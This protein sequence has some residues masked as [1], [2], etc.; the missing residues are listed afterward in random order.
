MAP[1]GR[2]GWKAAMNKLGVRMGLLVGVMLTVP[3]LAVFYVGY[4]LAGLPFTPFVPLDWASRMLPG[5]IITFGIDTM[6]SLIRALGLGVADTAKLA[7]QFISVGLTV[8]IGGLTGALTFRVLRDRPTE[9]IRQGVAAG[10]LLGIVLF[11]LQLSLPESG[12]ANPLIAGIWTIGVF[13]VWGLALGYAYQRLRT[14]TARAGDAT[15]KGIDRRTF[16]VQM[17]GAAAVVTVAGAGV[18]ALL[19]ARTPDETALA[20]ATPSPQLMAALPNAGDPVLPAPGTRAEVTP[21][22]KHYRIDI[23]LL[24]PVVPADGY[25][26]PFTSALGG[27]KVTLKEYTLDALIDGFPAVSDYLTMGCISNNVGGDLIS[28]ILWTG[29]PMQAL[30]ADVGVPDGATHLK[31]RAADGFDE[32][33]ALDLINSDPRVMLCYAWEGQPLTVEHG[34]PLRIHIPNHY[35]MKQPKWITEFEFVPQDEDGYW[36]RRGWDKQALVRATSVID[37]VAVDS[38]YTSGEQTL[39]PVGGIAWSGDRGI[40][41][42]EVQVDDGD[43]VEAQLRAPISDRTWVI[44]RYDWPFAAGSHTFTVRATEGDGTPQIEAR[45]GVRPSGATGYH[46]LRATV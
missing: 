6:I 30:L 15:V 19:S 21:L 2:W 42:V 26:L 27:D 45:E 40:S 9:A 16:L 5:P 11:A 13:V 17:G 12:A 34:F 1:N 32:T 4:Q 37:T 10:A 41:K 28:T 24:P 20:E 7:E 3:L 46:Q 36:V 25:V 29:L 8:A 18:G 44:W 35:G 33:I 31:M 22:A 23:N 39:I 14:E 43:W 38:A